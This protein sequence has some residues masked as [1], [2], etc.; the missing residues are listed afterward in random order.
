MN[1]FLIL[2]ILF[3]SGFT[4]FTGIADGDPVLIWIGAAMFIVVVGFCFLERE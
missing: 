1:D 4:V 2:G 3:C